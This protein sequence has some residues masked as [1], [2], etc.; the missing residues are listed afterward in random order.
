MPSSCDFLLG[1]RSGGKRFLLVGVE[2]I[3]TLQNLNKGYI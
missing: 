1:S 3:A 2:V